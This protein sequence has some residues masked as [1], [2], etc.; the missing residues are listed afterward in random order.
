MVIAHWLSTIIDAD[1]IYVVETGKVI[2]S[3]T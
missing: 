1:C 3:G 2:Q